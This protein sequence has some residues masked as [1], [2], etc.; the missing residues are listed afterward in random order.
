MLFYRCQSLMMAILT[1]LYCT[2]VFTKAPSCLAT[3]SSQT[4]VP[5]QVTLAFQLCCIVHSLQLI[6]SLWLGPFLEGLGPAWVWHS[7]NERPKAKNVSMVEFE[8]DR[9]KNIARFMEHALYGI[10][11]ALLV[12]QLCLLSNRHFEECFTSSK[13]LEA[14][15]TWMTV[16]IFV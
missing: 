10:V 15:R 11:I 3:D 6:V 4:D 8:S 7:S 14:D 5:Q 1:A 12:Y 13:E 16:L 2:Q 9:R